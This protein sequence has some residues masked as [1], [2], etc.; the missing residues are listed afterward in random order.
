MISDWWVDLWK[1]LRLF[2][3]KMLS[4]VQYP[5][6]L[7]CFC[8]IDYN[9]TAIY[10]LTMPYHT[11]LPYLTKPKYSSLTDHNCN[12]N[13]CCAK[14]YHTIP[15]IPGSCCLVTAEHT[16]NVKWFQNDELWNHKWLNLIDSAC[17]FLTKSFSLLSNNHRMTRKK[18]PHLLT[19]GGRGSNWFSSQLLG[20]R[21][22]QDRG[23]VC[24]YNS[25]V[26]CLEYNW[27]IV[28]L[29][30]CFLVLHTEFCIVCLS[31]TLFRCEGPSRNR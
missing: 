19:L 14:P 31:V 10:V 25:I 22:P 8:S 7:S 9:P 16:K 4:N 17:I 5:L 11:I 20:C 2:W 3:F 12:C 27:Y 18:F 30:E 21:Q 29:E 24:V 15:Y 1:P 23:R 26:K 28:A 13:C 6:C